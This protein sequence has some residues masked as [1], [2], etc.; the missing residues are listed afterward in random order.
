MEAVHAAYAADAVWEDNTGL[1]GDW[2]TPRGPE[3][4]QGAWRRW[5]EAF[6]E[7]QFEWDEVSDA[8][9]DVVV[10]YRSKARGRGSGAVVDQ[11]ITLLWTLQAGK[12]VR[13]RAYADR[14][15]ALTAAGLRE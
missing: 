9:D 2:G 15:E 5:Y 8:G 1:W 10:T 13:I 11:A 4:I 7:V 3:G 12:V 14:A 6:D